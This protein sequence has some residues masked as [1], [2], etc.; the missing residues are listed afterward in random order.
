V[1][2]VE[3]YS[4]DMATERSIQTDDGSG[5]EEVTTDEGSLFSIYR[6]YI[7][8]PESR[9]D[10]YVGFGTFFGGI[11]LGFVGLVLFLYSGTQP[12]GSALFWQL[13]EVALVAVML[14]LP[15]VALS[16]TVL[17]PVGRRT[18]GA[19]I[20]GAAI[21]VA[22]AVWLTQV[23]PYQWTSAGNDITV[24]TTY[25][26]GIVLLAASTGSSLVAQYVDNAVPQEAD[27]PTPD[28]E[29]GT[30]SISD[31]QVSEDIEEAMSDSSLTWGGVEKEPNTKRLKFDMPEDTAIDEATIE[32][33]TETRSSGDDVDDAV[34]GLRQ[35]QG[36]EQETGR[37]ES[38]DDQVSAL[39]EFR[40]QQEDDDIETGVEAERG[41]LGWLRD[42]LFG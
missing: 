5:D 17:L 29:E 36:G 18:M 1:I 14:G 27:T 8:E 19:S 39:T 26:V 21:C 16:F 3:Q 41:F 24:L 33:A 40:E 12:S 30:E 37:T 4:V 9:R 31:E 25:A 10:V 28:D 11:A 42:K 7:G 35:L 6:R 2:T 38:L 13:R 15:A 34:S 20:A 32:S 22:G 23:Y